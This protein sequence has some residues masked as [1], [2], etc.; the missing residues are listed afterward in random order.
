MRVA[1]GEC[2]H[3]NYPHV[4]QF[5]Y[6]E[7]VRFLLRSLRHGAILTGKQAA[8]PK[9]S[10]PIRPPTWGFTMSFTFEHD[11]HAIDF[12]ALPTKSQVWLAKEG[13]SHGYGNRVASSVI[14]DFRAEA[15]KA[16]IEAHSA[17]AWKALSKSEQS[18]IEK[19]GIPDSDSA[20][21]REAI[22]AG[23]E[24]FLT[25]MLVGELSEGRATGP[26]KSP[27]E[28]EMES[29]A[30]VETI[31]ILIEKRLFFV[32]AKRRVP[33]ADDEFVLGSE[34]VSFADLCARRLARQRDRIERQAAKILA[35][36]EKAANKAG[37]EDLAEA[38]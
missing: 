32:S 19:S 29:I 36:R 24:E 7:F 22:K 14:G 34:T 18:A 5:L 25:A 35:E 15:R 26:R 33:K 1:R 17:D 8:K 16:W 28:V 2:K 4:I 10:R 20:E 27:L 30:K 9:A 6:D 12:G 38:F 23:R 21:Y 3:E 31:K 11:G 37:A 13:F